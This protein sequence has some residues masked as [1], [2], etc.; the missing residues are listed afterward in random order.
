MRCKTLVLTLALLFGVLSGHPEAVS[1]FDWN[2]V[3]EEALGYL[4]EYIRID[5]T[6]PPGRTREAAEF[7]KGI[8][9]GEGIEVTLF[10][11]DAEA[12]KVNLLART[13]G[14]REKKPLLLLNHMDVVPAAGEGWAEDPF[15]ALERDGYLWGRGTLDMKG[16]GIIE[17]MALILIK[18]S[19]QELDRDI[20]FLS[21]CDEESGRAL[22]ASWM[23]ENHWEALDPGAVIDEGGFIAHNLFA[24]D[25]R[26]YI[27]PSVD[28]KR[29]LWL[30]LTA[31]GEG[32][33]GSMPHSLNPNLI[34]VDALNRIIGISPQEGNHETVTQLKEAVGELSENP[35]TYAIMHHTISLTSLT[36]GVGDPPKVNVIPTTAE[37]TLDCRLLPGTSVDEFI[38]KIG[39]RISDPRVRIDVLYRPRAVSEAGSVD[40]LISAVETVMQREF[41]GSE[42]VPILLPGGTD[43]RFFRA[44]GV[45][46]IGFTPIEVDGETLGLLHGDNERIS[47][48]GFRRGVRLFYEILSEM[49]Q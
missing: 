24:E 11:S 5:T 37:A 36:S 1:D 39:E 18:R 48:E 41:P 10:E 44:R 17:M 45:P 30:K 40:E 9:E 29:V 32:G 31:D 21:V 12:G 34:L 28:E 46:A 19:G 2:A 4:K 42:T 49:T 15:A 8:L 14:H 23:I 43:S 7:L 38:D 22:G 35:F 27:A 6:N 16:M 47:V 33:H 20:L 25:G 3:E 13:R 26:Y